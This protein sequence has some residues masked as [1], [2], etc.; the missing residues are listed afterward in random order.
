MASYGSVTFVVS[1][2]WQLRFYSDATVIGIFIGSAAITYFSIGSK[3]V[4]YTANVTQS[5]S[6][7]FT[8]MSSQFN[9]T[10][11]I[12]RLRQIFIM[13][14][15][16]CA[17]IVFPLCALLIIL[18]KSIITAWVGAK[19]VPL[20][21]TVLV[22]MAIG[23]C[24]E[25]AQ[26][27]SSKILYG[28]ARHR[29]LACVRLVEGLANLALSVALLHYYG[30]VGVAVGTLIP[31]LCSN[32]LF[33][34]QHLCRVLGVGLRTYLRQAYLAPLLLCAPMVALLLW[35]H[36]AFPVRNYKELL[37][38]A[39]ASGLVYGIGLTW[40]LLT[41]EQMGLQ[42]RAKFRQSWLKGLRPANPI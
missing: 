13:G 17:L 10:G 40:F 18:G 25:G 21:Y 42:L 34:P 26:S 2:A 31:Q 27:A 37:L 30:I 35:L 3:L 7:I 29:T 41:Q 12:E 38:Q 16:A 32:L 6:Q 22:I 11:E 33:L 9:A 24:T 14:N 36:F 20:G 28:M 1:I 39:I 5:M 23:D 19:Y 15:R 4:S 8:P